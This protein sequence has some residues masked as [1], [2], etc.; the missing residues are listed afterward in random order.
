MQIRPFREKDRTQVVDLWNRCGL[1]VAWNDPNRDIDRKL[2]RDPGLFLVGCVDGV[3]GTVMAGYDGH[4]GWIN[5]LAVDPDHRGRGYGKALM[6]AAERRLSA[7]G[8]P[9][10]NLQVRS[11]N[12]GTIEFYTSI[13]YKED[14]VISLGKRLIHDD[15]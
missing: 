11:T 3:V 7:L 8:C 6:Q 12:I 1:T 13:G 9:K 10:I 2:D 4:R 14:P 5:Y 15:R